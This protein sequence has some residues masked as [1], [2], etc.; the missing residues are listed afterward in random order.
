MG[1]RDLF[2]QI[3]RAKAKNLRLD[4]LLLEAIVEVESAWNPYAV[5][6]E[7]DFSYTLTPRP[8]AVRNGISEKTEKYLQK[9]SWGLGQIMGGTARTLGY[10]GPLVRLTEV[11]TNIDLMCAYLVRFC[12]KYPSIDKQIAAYN[13]GSVVLTEQGKFKNQIY[14]D[15]V[16]AV[17]AKNHPASALGVSSS[18]SM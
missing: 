4:P 5:R 11:E 18:V 16:L 14:V 12:K 13:A 2:Q 10:T 8:F 9:F 7:P 3:V 17:M 15:K 1:E 6:F